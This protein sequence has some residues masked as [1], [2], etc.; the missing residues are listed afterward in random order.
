MSLPLKRNNILS[1]LLFL[2]FLATPA[3]S[4][5]MEIANDVA[6]TFHIEPNHLPKAGVPAKAWFA[7]TRRGGQIIPLSQC[8]C[9]LAVY[10]M[11]RGS[12]TV[13]QPPLSS[14]NV[15]RYSGIPQ[16][17]ITFP[18]AGLYALEL[19]GTAKPGADFKPFRF[20]YQVTVGR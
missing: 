6:A 13:W 16:A 3:W 19:T 9:Q 17:T 1:S 7:L 11:P 18:K 4:H 8:N 10:P 15:E 20:S 5:E 12:G 14:L 2:L